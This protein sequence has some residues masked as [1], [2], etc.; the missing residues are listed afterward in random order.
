MKRLLLYI[1]LILLFSASQQRDNTYRVIPQNILRTGEKMT[2]RVHYGMVNAAEAIMQIDKDIYWH[3]QRPCFK[4]DV[5]G[6]TTGFFDMMMRVRD[7]WG[8]YVD[9]AALVPQRFYRY[10]EEGRYRKK[11]IVDF[12]HR[13]DVAEVHRLDKHTGKLKGKA[14]FD[15]P[16]NV[17]DIVSGY[18]FLR[19]FDFDTIRTN[20]MFEVV[21][22]FD[23]TTYHLDVKLVSRE[24][25]KTKIGEFDAVVLS[26]VMP[27]NSLFRGRYPVKAW[28]SDDKNKIPLKI[29]AELFI[30]SLEIDIKEYYRGS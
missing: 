10:I 5:F 14:H 24:R 4:I 26:P 28:I 16:N 22:F 18:Y 25:L 3:N 27:E 15:I 21:G 2:Y 29:K 8:S 13:E 12:H 30:G 23:D 19:T 6:N 9:T 1:T 20:E 7:N 11:E 17:Q